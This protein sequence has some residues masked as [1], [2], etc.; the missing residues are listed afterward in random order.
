MNSGLLSP[1]LP[2][3]DVYATRKKIVF[4]LERI[5]RYRLA[6]KRNPRVLDFGCGNGASLGQFVIATGV[7]YLGVD[8]HE[9]S[10]DYARMNFGTS[11]ARFLQDVP[12]GECFDIILYSEVLEH[13]PDPVAVLC[14]HMPLL[15]DDGIVLGSI[16][17]GY[18][19]TEI[20][21]YVDR[22]L[23]I[24]TGCRRIWRMVRPRCGGTLGDST[25]PY[26]HESGHVQFFTWPSFVRTV[27][28][29]GLAVAKHQN[30]SVMGADFTGAT[31]LRFRPLIA[32][33][34]AAADYL[35]A[36]AAATWHF[37]LVRQRGAA[38]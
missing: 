32:I 23:H 5:E 34:T 33:N 10:L 6:I 7:D 31:V 4:I 29:A 11:N 14:A 9:D 30:G 18:G 37:E 27:A 3:E 22:K 12:A 19:L 38:V 13:L 36:W 24:Y 21:K 2:D 25:L 28:A 20:E 26:N 35:P 16:P 17:N 1:V 8:M 15:A